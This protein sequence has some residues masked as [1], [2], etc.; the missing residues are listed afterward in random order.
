MAKSMK[1]T[2]IKA[3]LLVALAA[4]AMPS[5]AG[6]FRQPIY[7]TNAYFCNELKNNDGNLQPDRVFNVMKANE[8]KLRAAF[9]MNLVAD[10]GTHSLE[11]DLM[12]NKA[13]KIDTIKLQPVEASENDFAYT[14]VA[15]FG[16]S[17]PLG[18]VFFKIYDAVDGGRRRPVGTVR[19]MTAE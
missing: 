12:N 3:L 6:R 7:I 5:L 8:E 16:G 15:M 2:L 14:A 17:M 19:L 1:P 11:V 9:V 10:K 18:G 4:T 13:E